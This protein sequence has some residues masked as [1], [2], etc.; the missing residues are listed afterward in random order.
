MKRAFWREY[1]RARAIL[2]IIANCKEINGRELRESLWTLGAR[3]GVV[4]FYHLMSRFE[5]RGLVVGWYQKR[6]HGVHTY[7]ERMYRL[8]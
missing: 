4:G 6:E 2:R 1:R 3:M 8:R 7:W 5:D